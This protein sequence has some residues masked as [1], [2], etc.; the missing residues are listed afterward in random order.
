MRLKTTCLIVLCLLS[1]YFLISYDLL[2]NKVDEV[3]FINFNSTLGW[4]KAYQLFWAI[5]NHKYHD[6]VIDV[7]YLI[8][9]VTYIL[10][11]D[12]KPRIQ[13]I[14]ESLSVAAT[15][16][17]VIAFINKYLCRYYLI[18]KATSPSLKY[19]NYLD[20]NQL[21]PLIKTK[22]Y[23]TSTFPG[24]HATTA[25]LFFFLTAPLL[26][27]KT[28]IALMV[29]TLIILCPRLIAG[30]HNLSDI[31]VGSLILALVISLIHNHCLKLFF[32]PTLLTQ[33]PIL[34]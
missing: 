19:Q 20:L 23:A 14:V 28:T 34:K 16:A 2:W 24:D 13:K 26:P 22:I 12:Q 3:F 30:A 7:V 6:W 33:P 1:S 27:K 18:I 11:T 31:C 25:L 21:V 8:I 29:Y 10:K 4:G 32:K 9:I 5:L 17:F 15:I